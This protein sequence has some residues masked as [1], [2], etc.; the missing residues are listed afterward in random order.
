VPAAGQFVPLQWRHNLGRGAKAVP[1]AANGLAYADELTLAR[2]AM[3][4]LGL[5]FASVDL[6]T[7][8]KRPMVLEVN[9]GVMLEVLSRGHAPEAAAMLID[10]IYHRVLDQALAEGS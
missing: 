7:V 3:R 4:A 6:V 1:F 8:A 2:A 5:R 9:A 10:G